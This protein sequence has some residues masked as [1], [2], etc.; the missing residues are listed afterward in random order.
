MSSSDTAAPRAAVPVALPPLR[1]FYW[2]L[3]RELWEH[4]AIWM[5]PLVIG[6]VALL[7]ALFSTVKLPHAVR[8]VA[9]AVATTPLGMK[10]AVNFIAGPYAFV[11]FAAVI[12]GLLVAMAYSLGALHTER[13]DRSILFWKSLPVSDLITVLAKAVMPIVVTPVAQLAVVFAGT[14]ILMGFSALVVLASGQDL[15]VWWARVP[16]PKI[17]LMLA[18]GLPFMALWYAPI[19]AWF[20]LVS[21]WARRTPYLWAIAP[22]LLLGLVE[23]IVLG[24]HA[25]WSW[26][27]FRAFG[28]FFGGMGGSKAAATHLTTAPLTTAQTANPAAT[29]AAVESAT[30]AIIRQAVTPHPP[31]VDPATWS[32]PHLWIGLI[33]AAVFLAAAVWLRRSR[34][35]I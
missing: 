4:R 7:A 32:G 1:V 29:H 14:L 31:P 26:L 3:R 30:H 21:A 22:P 8:V 28:V 15:S 25:V 24:T 18:D 9:G 35:P 23:R 19:Y 6:G 27:I 5:A 10:L 12:T 11:A 2:S 13:R 33:L 20:I 17:W 34:D 16:I